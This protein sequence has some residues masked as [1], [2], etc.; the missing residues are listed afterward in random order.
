MI[1]SGLTCSRS[2]AHTTNRTLGLRALIHAQ[3]AQAPGQLFNSRAQ[4]PHRKPVRFKPRSSDL[5][6]KS[7]LQPIPASPVVPLG[8][9]R[10]L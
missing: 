5:E 3:P 7:E 6:L 1:T 8:L 9:E 2:T 4:T 10:F